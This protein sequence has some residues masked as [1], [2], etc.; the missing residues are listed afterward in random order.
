MAAELDKFDDPSIVTK[1]RQ[2]E[3]WGAATTAVLME[4]R[5]MSVESA[6]SRCVEIVKNENNAQQYGAIH[7]L[8]KFKSDAIDALDGLVAEGYTEA[9]TVLAEQKETLEAFEVL[10]WHLINNNNSFILQYRAKMV[11]LS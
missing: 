7:C 3:N 6:L 11:Q 2:T 9:I 8:G 4:V 5:D 10:C 1:L